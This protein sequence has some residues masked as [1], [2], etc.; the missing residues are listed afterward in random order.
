[1][2]QSQTKG[3]STGF[4]S[5]QKFGIRRHQA[6]CWQPISQMFELCAF[7]AAINPLQ[8]KQA[9]PHVVRRAKAFTTTVIELIAI[10]KAARGGESNRPKPGRRRPAAIG[11]AIRL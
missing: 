10:N 3:G 1:M 5:E 4:P 11:R 8:H 2:A 9:P 6:A 7:A